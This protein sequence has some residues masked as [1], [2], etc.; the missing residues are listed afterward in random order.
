MQAEKRRLKLKLDASEK[1]LITYKNKVDFLNKELID[2]EL[3]I[4]TDKDEVY[5]F[6]YC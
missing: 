1:E 2:K 3:K 5:Y 6:V 4:K